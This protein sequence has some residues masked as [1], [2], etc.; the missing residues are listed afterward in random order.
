MMPPLDP[1]FKKNL[2]LYVMV[3]DYPDARQDVSNW[4]WKI[5]DTSSREGIKLPHLKETVGASLL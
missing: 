3:L 1:F 2:S 4:F 5:I